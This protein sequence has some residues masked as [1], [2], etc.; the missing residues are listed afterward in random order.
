MPGSGRED[1]EVI[2]RMDQIDEATKEVVQEAL[3]EVVEADFETY[4]IA[5]ME[6][7][8]EMLAATLSS[9]EG[10]RKVRVVIDDT[11]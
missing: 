2:M 4:E 1:G 9:R 5:E 11:S 3:E 10:D 8:D 6:M 7:W